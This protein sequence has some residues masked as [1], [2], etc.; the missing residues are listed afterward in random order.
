MVDMCR[1][2]SQYLVQLV[3][4]PHW[5]DVCDARDQFAGLRGDG[6]MFESCILVRKN[7]MVFDQ[8]DS[9]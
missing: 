1:S 6:V 5:F 8:K 9:G 2:A 7:I 4:P 3:D